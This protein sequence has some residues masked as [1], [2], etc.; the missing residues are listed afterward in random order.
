MLDADC[1]GDGVGNKNLQ[2]GPNYCCCAWR[3]LDEGRGFVVGV[4]I[5]V[6]LDVVDNER[7]R[8]VGNCF[9]AEIVTYNAFVECG[10]T[11]ST[12]KSSVSASFHDFKS[13]RF[14]Q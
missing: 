7:A 3:F 1:P 5:I 10:N 9:V 6:T 4:V 13:N 12:M 8:E 11:N 14:S 2:S